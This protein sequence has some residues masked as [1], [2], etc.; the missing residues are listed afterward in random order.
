MR[1]TQ[2]GRFI[3]GAVHSLWVDGRLM[4][5]VSLLGFSWCLFS[6][7]HSPGAEKKLNESFGEELSVANYNRMESGSLIELA[8]RCF[9]LVRPRLGERVD[10]QLRWVR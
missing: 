10:Q 4:E 2:G 3:N 8:S 5:R 7:L 1:L 6:C 9:L